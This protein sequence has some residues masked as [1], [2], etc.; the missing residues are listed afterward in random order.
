MSDYTKTTNFTAKDALS[1][2]DP[3]K[4]IKGSTF[5]TEFDALATASATKAN[6]IASATNGNIIKQDANGDLVDTGFSMA[7]VAGNITASHTEINQLASRTLA[8]TDDVID[9]F[10]SGT[11]MLF[12][13]T[14]A[15]TGW[16]KQT[17]H[18]DKA[19]RIVSGTASSGGTTAFSSISASTGGSHTLI[20]A[21]VPAHDHG[22]AGSHTHTVVGDNGG[23]GGTTA[24]TY[25]STASSVVNISVVNSSGAHTHTSYGGGGGHT[26]PVGLDMQYVDI[27]IASKD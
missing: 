6:K 4:V 11:L 16:T 2:G 20:E 14:A 5:D 19:L 22:S 15:P 23:V 7:N 25:T 18:N 27:I 24:V 1:S 3:N 13:Q 21:E 12:Q 26:H 8:S 10:P 17:T 9:N